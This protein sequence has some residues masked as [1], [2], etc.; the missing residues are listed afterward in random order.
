[1]RKI[2][3]FL[4]FI[5]IIAG[6]PVLGQNEWAPIGAKWYYNYC[7]GLSPQYA[8]YL[9]YESVNDT[10]ISNQSCKKI[11]ITHYKYNG[12]SIIFG[13]E[14]MY[15]DSGKVFYWNNNQFY[16]IYDFTASVGDTF[17]IGYREIE[18]CN[19][20]MVNVI[21]DSIDTVFI[22][23]ISLKRF[24]IHYV[25]EPWG[26]SW[27]YYPQ[28][29][30]IGS[31]LLMF[32]GYT[33]IPE[34]PG[35]LRCYKDPYISYTSSYWSLSDS[36]DFRVISNVNTTINNNAISIFPNLVVDNLT[37]S[38]EISDNNMLK[39][40][41]VDIVGRIRYCQNFNEFNN[42]IDLTDLSPGIYSVLF[43]I[44]NSIIKTTKIVKL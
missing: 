13:Y 37:V 29:E 32:G 8:E 36:C 4:I 39:M 24:F 10:L 30:K 18:C 44:D 28:I 22:S 1:M 11:I 3:L 23:G 25:P 26:S 2:L 33:P 12:D 9:K 5:P 14:Y 42:L 41:I 6:Q 21:V 40:I 31:E 38:A 19:I 7:I 43:N 34:H 35:P 20:L 16:L 27:V 17:Q 15:E